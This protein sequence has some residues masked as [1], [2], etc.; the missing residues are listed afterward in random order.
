MSGVPENLIAL[1]YQLGVLIFPALAPVVVWVL[2]NWREVEAY[3]E[4][5]QQRSD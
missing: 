5:W 3:I 4:A 2:G 1:C